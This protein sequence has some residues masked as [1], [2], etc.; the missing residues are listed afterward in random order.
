MRTRRSGD[1]AYWLRNTTRS[2]AARPAIWAEATAAPIISLAGPGMD[3]ADACFMT[4]RGA[5]TLP[6]GWDPMRVLPS[7]HA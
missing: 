3:S 7:R 6:W 4:E 2:M 5:R 1:S